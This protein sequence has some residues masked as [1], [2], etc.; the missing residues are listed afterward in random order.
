MRFLVN[1]PITCPARSLVTIL[2]TRSFSADAVTS[3]FGDTGW[4]AR[5]GFTG[6]PLARLPWIPP[7]V[8]AA[9]LERAG[10]CRRAHEIAARMHY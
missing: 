5:R 3:S 4:R 8:R 9:V 7:A 1:V 2:D 6:S 10:V